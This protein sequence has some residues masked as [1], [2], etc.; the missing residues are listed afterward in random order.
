M[1]ASA[2]RE[3]PQAIVCDLGGVLIGIDF[4]RAIETWARHSDLSRSEL[5]AAFRFDRAYEQ[6][7]RGEIGAGEYFAHLRTALRLNASDA[8]IAAGWNAILL[9]EIQETLA[10]LERARQQV[11]TYLF[12]NSNA[13]H[14][15]VWTA[16]YPRVVHAFDGVFVSCDLGFRKPEPEAF[17]AVARRIGLPLETIL[18]LDDTL[19]N[20]DGARAVG[21]QAL[22]VR[23]SKDV[24]D[25]LDPV[26]RTDP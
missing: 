12:S 1:N 24:A 18:F 8:E 15:A 21:M 7:E 2:P 16:R 11:P 23:S 3:S 9:G 10:L 17:K 13:V 6:H 19:E 25:A 26:Y 20:V 5:R 14:K 4:E 22:H